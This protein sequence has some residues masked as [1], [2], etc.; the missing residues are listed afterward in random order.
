MNLQPPDPPEE[1]EGERWERHLA[2]VEAE[3]VKLRKLLAEKLISQTMLTGIIPNDGGM[4]I[5]LEGGACAIMADC[6][7]E[8][9]YTS[10][11]VN[12]IEAY[13]TSGK[14]PDLG[15]ITVTV[16]RETGKTPHQLRLDAEGGR[17]RLKAE[18]EQLSE[19]CM[20]QEKLIETLRAQP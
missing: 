16:K 17:D 8:Q 9:L 1:D 15:H 5:G 19:T 2:E 18:C 7:G 6:F 14:Y 10:G 13:F 3:N 11:A 4:T 20:S 12:Y